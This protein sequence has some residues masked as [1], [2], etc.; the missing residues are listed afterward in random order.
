[1]SKETNIEHLIKL[2]RKERVSLFIGA[3]FSL[4]AKA[5]SAW[6][7]Q[8]AILNELPSE[9]LKKTHAADGLDEISQFFVEE[10]CEGSR[11]ELMDLL[12]KL[13]EFEPE[14]MDDHYALAAIPHFHNIFTTNYDTLLEDSYPKERCAVVKKDEDCVYM[15]SKPVRVFKIHGD[16]TNRDF[17]VITSQDYADL[18]KQKHNPLVWNEVKSAFTRTNVAFIGYSLSDENIINMIKLISKIVNRNQQQMFLIA[19]G[20]S[21]TKKI[22][23][24]KNHVS[25][26]DAT[27]KEFLTQVK[28]E[29]DKNIGPDYRH[30]DVSEATF[31]IYC[32][33]NGFDPI[34]KRTEQKKKDNEIINFAPLKGKSIE[35][36]INFTVKNQPKEMALDFDFEKYGSFIKDDN[37]PFPDVPYIRFNEDDITDATHMVN[38]LVM[39]CGF[40]KILVA[41]SINT[42]DL[43]IIIP[44]RNFMEK[45]K[46]QAYRLNGTK[47]VI[48]F[49]CHIY[50]VKIVLTPKTNFGRGIS[51]SFTFDMKETYTDNNLA[52]KW[53]DF[54]C[55]FFNKE[56]FYIKEISSNIF[57][58]GNEYSA[59]IKHNFNDFKKYYD[60]IR[61]IEMHS[62]VYFKTYDQCTERNLT[63]AYYIVAFLAHKPITC[64]CKGG[65]EFSTTELICDDE[66]VERAESNLPVSI[67]RTETKE[68][69]YTLNGHTFVIPYTHNVYTPCTVKKIAK[70]KEGNMSADLKYNGDSYQIYFSTQSARE[71]FPNVKEFKRVKEAL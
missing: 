64:E 41:P 4:E 59:E 19:P 18:K 9:E 49:D 47:F 40:K 2:I 31:T 21:E 30:H 28:K 45:V 56:D 65:A 27:A 33:Q 53:I 29:I 61:Y 51:L 15:D 38:G 26:I 62:D 46:A 42:I 23:L 17:V 58:T 39:A 71:F 60:Y 50:T 13:F 11:A 70:L 52:I 14:S 68:K 54:A 43:T 22:Q 55:A 32:E 36:K 5:P 12:Q 20:V 6:D 1:M 24:K 44:C 7:L 34:V 10:V 8:Q 57:N 66:F 25:Y 69:R 67:V 48:Q 35:H 16:F 37:L 3:G 63:L